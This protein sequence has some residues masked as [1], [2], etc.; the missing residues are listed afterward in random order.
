MLMQRFGIYT[1]TIFLSFFSATIYAESLRPPSVPLVACD[2]YFSVWSPADKLTDTDTTHWTG[3]PQRLT[4]LVQI[5]GKSFR[6]MGAEPAALPA[7]PQT[8]LQVLPTRTIYTFEG[9]GIHL[10]LTF[11]TADLPGDID[12]LSRP[13]T[14]LTW[15][16]R[17][18]DGQSHK[19]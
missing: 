8:N 9:D 18:M 19:V 4:S 6:I 12:L 10:V 11:M 3:K 14:Y 17:S 2:P 7:L 15:D 1:L 16:A 13:V 5:D